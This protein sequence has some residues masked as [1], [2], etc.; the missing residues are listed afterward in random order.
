M[1]E[2]LHFHVSITA[3]LP[4]PGISVKIDKAGIS[5]PLL[6]S[7]LGLQTMDPDIPSRLRAA[8]RG[9]WNLWALPGALP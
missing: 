8:T 2:R 1:T 6:V 3:L 9:P 7:A 5:L 4:S